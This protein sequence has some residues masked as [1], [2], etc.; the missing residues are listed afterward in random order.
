MFVIFFNVSA[1]NIL[2]S[3]NRVYTHNDEALIVFIIP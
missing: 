2:L 1:L 3:R